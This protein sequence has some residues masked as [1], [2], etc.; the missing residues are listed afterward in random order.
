MSGGED[1]TTLQAEPAVRLWTVA[2]PT[3]HD[4]HDHKEG[5]DV[6]L[7]LPWT[8]TEVDANGISNK[9]DA[10][11]Q[12]LSNE[13]GQLS[14]VASERTK[15]IGSKAADVGEDAGSK[16]ADI[17]RDASS[18][19]SNLADQVI[20]GATALGASLA[21]SSRSTVKDLSKDA[22]AL[23]EDLR[24]VRITTEPKRSGANPMAG[25]AL[26]G[27][28]TAGLA[29]MYF[30]D[31]DRGRRRRALLRDQFTKLTRVS[32]EKASGTAQDLRNRTAGV[33][34]ETRKAV[35][36]AASEAEDAIEGEPPSYQAP[37][38]NS[39]GNGL[40]GESTNEQESPIRVG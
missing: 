16:T 8:A 18:A 17:A 7:T 29:L 1:A 2:W 15:D 11:R 12:A 35:S 39:Y 10:V 19:A 20:K 30:F 14:A 40:T 28:F 4:G 32:R 21:A 27:G 9:L 24:N 37:W 23:G 31:P 5:R 6:K 38:D 34:A 3:G 13:A 33:M 22:Q 36:G 25:V 26:L